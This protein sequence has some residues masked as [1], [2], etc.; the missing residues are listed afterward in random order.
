M[1]STPSTFVVVERE[2]RLPDPGIPDMHVIRVDPDR[3]RE[4]P[5]VIPASRSVVLVAAEA[6][7]EM[8]SLWPSLP[9]DRR[10]R[11]FLFVVPADRPFLAAHLL[12]MGAVV[13]RDGQDPLSF[14]IAAVLA[15]AF[16]PGVRTDEVVGEQAALPGKA[17][18]GPEDP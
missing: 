8:V 4:T 13:V 14:G 6:V 10:G 1:I 15:R 2:R 7:D 18:C 16:G 12:G 17:G 11:P 5:G 9:A 3:L